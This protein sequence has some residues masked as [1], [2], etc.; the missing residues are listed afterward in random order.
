MMDVGLKAWAEIVR[1]VFPELSIL[2]DRSKWLAGDFKLPA[3]F[4]ETDLVSD[5][6]HTPRADRIIE[7]V[8]L[9]FHYDKERAD[10]QDEEPIPLDLD[11]F[12]TYLRQQRFNVPSKRFGVV[13][14]IE[15]PRT[16]KK[17]DQVEVTFRY[18]YLLSVPKP[19]VNDDGSPIQKINNFY[20]SHNGEEF[21]A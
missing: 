17:A 13:L 14:V 20:I 16:R 2:R 6:V 21:D 4:I 10:E 18:S 1:R 7:D 9:V 12:F 3:V 19:L 11:P 5:K 15:P 8:G